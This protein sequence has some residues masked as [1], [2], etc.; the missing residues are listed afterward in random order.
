MIYLAESGSTKC[1]AIFMSADGEEVRRIRTIGFNPY[2]HDRAFVAREIQKVPAVQE[3]GEK[4]SQVYFYGAGCSTPRLQQEIAQ[5]LQA[6]FPHADVQVDHDLTAA[7][8]ATYQGEPEITCIFGTG[9]NCVHY[10]GQQITPG[11]SGYGFIIGDEG[12]A[13]YIGKQLIRGYLYQTMPEGYRKAFYE[14]YQLSEEEIREKVYAR[15]GANVFLGNLAPFAHAH[16]NEPYFYQLVFEGFREFIDTQV[17]QF[18]EARSVAVSFVGSIA[19]HFEPV[20]RD[21]LQFFDLRLGI[22]VRRPI[23]GLIAYHRSRVL[24]PQNP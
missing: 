23:D 22:I 5:G 1:D 15:E 13:S 2:F 3:L 8:Y 10:D 19:Y 7:A 12:S 18:P 6:G 4:V 14:Q 11:N 9:S 17:M 16:I 20:L 24:K 21:V